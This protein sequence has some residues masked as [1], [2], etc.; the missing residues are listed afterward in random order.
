MTAPK[1]RWFRAR[2]VV[3]GPSRL[4]AALEPEIRAQV[5]DEY[6][7]HLASAGRWRRF[8]LKLKIDREVGRRV[9]CRAHEIVS[10][11]ALY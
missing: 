10:R 6:A 8:C 9:S 4:H 11:D 2:F 1:R 7:F 3:D 5:I